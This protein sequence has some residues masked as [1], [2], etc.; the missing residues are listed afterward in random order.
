MLLISNLS[1]VGST[2]SQQ[3]SDQEL[4]TYYSRGNYR[5]YNRRNNISKHYQQQ[6][7]ARSTQNNMTQTQ[8]TKQRKNHVIE[9]GFS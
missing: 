8:Q 1:I 9:T 4:D 5:N 7:K 2:N 6:P 3:T